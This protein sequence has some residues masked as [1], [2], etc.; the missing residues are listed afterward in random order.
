MER[1]LDG[2][3]AVLFKEGADR[4]MHYVMLLLRS[5]LLSHRCCREFLL[6][7]LF[8]ATVAAS[9]YYLLFPV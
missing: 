6:L 5:P 2:R 3:N 1:F 8:V 4:G 7:S 9:H